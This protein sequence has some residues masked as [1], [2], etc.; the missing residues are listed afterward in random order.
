MRKFVLIAALLLASASAQAGESRSLSSYPDSDTNS[1]VP[2][3]P[4]AN[5]SLRAD[6]DTPATQPVE[7]PHYSPPPGEATSN[8]PP[9]GAASSP[10]RAIAIS[11]V[12][13]PMW[14][15]TANTNSLAAC[16]KTT[17]FDSGAPFAAP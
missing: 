12:P 16:C 2:S 8:P 17:P 1:T 6:N 7:T 4:V 13:D 9:D 11:L 10:L 3:Q 14:P 5:Q 15:T